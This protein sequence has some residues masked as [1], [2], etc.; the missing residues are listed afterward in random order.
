MKKL[1]VDTN[2]RNWNKT[3]CVGGKFSSNYSYAL[4]YL[5]AADI[6]VEHAVIE[7]NNK[8]DKLFYPICFNYRQ[9]IELTLKQL[10]I[11]SE[12]FYYKS[13]YLG[14]ELKKLNGSVSDKLDST[15]S[16]EKLLN[17]LIEIL[18]CVSDE[19]FDRNKKDLILE[20]HNL[21][22][23]GQKFR[24]P[25]QTNTLESFPKQTF[26]DLEKLKSGIKD[27]FEYFMGI[28]AWIDNYDSLADSIISSMQIGG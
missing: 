12:K 26:Y 10:I 8:K 28:D 19:K 5:Y 17:W 27:I 16:I 7:K 3:V 14:Y 20:F 21:D 18:D 2:G 13:E 11:Y 23:N 9:F 15:H 1:F 6:L 25:V 24:Y 4:G 22:S